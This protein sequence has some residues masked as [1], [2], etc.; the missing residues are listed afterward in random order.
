MLKAIIV[1]A[2]F[3]A[4]TWLVLR[5]WKRQDNNQDQMP[6]IED[7]TP[8]RDLPDDQKMSIKNCSEQA[9]YYDGPPMDGENM[10]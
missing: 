4:A 3:Y 5:R 9:K 8:A 6:D 7:V 1:L 2:C 10:K